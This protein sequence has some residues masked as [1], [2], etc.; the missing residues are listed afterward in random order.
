MSRIT[1][2]H[3]LSYKASVG[4]SLLKDY[5]YTYQSMAHAHFYNTVPY[6][7]MKK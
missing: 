1:E 6:C 2:A 3:P 7:I 5:R 4:G